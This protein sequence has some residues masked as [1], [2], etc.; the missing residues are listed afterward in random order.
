MESTKKTCEYMCPKLEPHKEVDSPAEQTHEAEQQ[1]ERK[2]PSLEQEPVSSVIATLKKRKM[3]ATPSTRTSVLVKALQTLFHFFIHVES[4]GD[5]FNLRDAIRHA[6]MRQ[7]AEQ[8]LELEI[9][10]ADAL[11]R[12]KL[13]TIRQW[14]PANDRKC[15]GN[16]AAVI[17]SY[18]SLSDV[19]MKEFKWFR[20]L[21]TVIVGHILLPSPEIHDALIKYLT[22][23]RANVDYG[24]VQKILNV[25]LNVAK[26]I[27]SRL[28]A[29]R[30]I[31]KVVLKKCMHS[32]TTRNR[33][34]KKFVK[35]VCGDSL[36]SQF[37][38][39]HKAQIQTREQ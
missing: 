12:S 15:F 31:G 26:N 19:L 2:E 32:S 14:L 3:I 4:M 18:E 11:A 10:R 30:T 28:D 36:S 22:S 29:E 9:E 33:P 35:M 20:E 24:L 6:F 34:C 1:E 5:M 23:V 39:Y 16:A 27:V 21:H 13:Q 7:H 17:V 25:P 37:C 38:Q 8:G